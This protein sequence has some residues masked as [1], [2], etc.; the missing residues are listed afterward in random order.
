MIGFIL[1]Y[2]AAKSNS[3]AK[4]RRASTTPCYEE[5]EFVVIMAPR[6]VVS[7]SF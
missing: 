3:R 7:A 2:S 4:G 5:W 1:G 6:V